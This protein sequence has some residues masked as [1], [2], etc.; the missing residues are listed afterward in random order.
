MTSTGGSA[1]V[2]PRADLGATLSSPGNRVAL[3][4]L[5]KATIAMV[6]LPIATLYAVYFTFQGHTNAVIFA[7]VA[8]AIVV[9]LVIATFVYVA[10]QEDVGPPKS[11]T[12]S[13]SASRSGTTSRSPI[14]Q[15]GRPK[16][17]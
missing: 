8:A 10:F 16:T 6:V 13:S 17:D 7:G 12:N 9:N 14:P 11:G 3:T 5:C 4:N 15:E 2:R 1:P